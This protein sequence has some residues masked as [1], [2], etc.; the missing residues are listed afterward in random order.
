MT[1]QITEK[2]DAAFTA[3]SRSKRVVTIVGIVAVSV[4]GLLL[5]CSGAAFGYQ[6]YYEGRVYP[7]VTAGEYSLAGLDSSA[8]KSEIENFNNR[9]SKK[10][11]QYSIHCFDVNDVNQNILPY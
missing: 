4:V 6:K 11:F 8:I 7:G 2:N 10:H 5:L 3:T 1:E 9:Y